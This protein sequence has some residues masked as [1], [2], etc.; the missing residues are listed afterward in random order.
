VNG[1]LV[2]QSDLSAADRT[3]MF[4]LLDAHF[5]G[6]TPGTF[7]RDLGAK[8][9]A[10]LI[11]RDGRLVGFS[12]I[13]LFEA[14]VDG[15]L[16]TVVC[17]GDTIVSPEAWGSIAFPRA[18]I[19][20]VYALRRDHP[21]GRFVW[22]LLTSGFRT[23]RFLPVFWR[24]FYPRFDAETPPQWQR[25]RDELAAAVYGKN[26]DPATGIVRFE[27][28]QRLRAG[29]A[30]VPAGRSDDPHI[31]FFLR[32]NPGHAGGDELVCVADLSPECLTPAGRRVVY[33]AG[34]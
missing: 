33:G 26:F 31:A 6:V 29:L 11:E 8:S 5:D 25:W 32:Q 7:A 10:V 1:R 16:L 23:Y 3:A 14:S 27:N 28:P 17:S 15:E 34:R 18:W 19:D 13:N 30:G 2:A 24:T 20:A 9:R 22:L 12:T 21:R 4:A